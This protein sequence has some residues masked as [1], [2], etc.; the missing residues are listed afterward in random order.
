MNKG[1]VTFIGVL[2]ALWVITLIIDVIMT[3]AL[4]PSRFSAIAQVTEGGPIQNRI[5]IYVIF[6]LPEAVGLFYPPYYFWA[7]WIGLVAVVVAA[8]IIIALYRSFPRFENSS[9]YRISEFFALNLFLS[10]LYIY[11]IAA[12]GHPIKSPISPSPA[13]F[14]ANFFSLTNAGLYEELITRVVFIGIPLFVYYAGT[15]HGNR[16]RTKPKRLPWWRIIWGGGYKFGKPEIIVLVISS[17][18]FGI[19]HAGSWDVSK[20]PQA[21]LGGL[22]LGVLYMRFGLYADV[23]FHFSIDSPSLLLPDTYGNPLAN[24]GTTGFYAIVILVFIA[25]GLIVSVVYIF[26]LG[27]LVRGRQ[28]LQPTA[29]QES[30]ETPNSTQERSTTRTDVVCRN[31]GS[32]KATFF[33]DDVYRCDSCGTVFKRNQ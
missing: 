4:Y 8:F 24:L 21:A 30:T 29:M 23:L 28:R 6:G 22:F 17:V 14:V 9:L 10:Y 25:A 15:S 1:Y 13:N 3:F 26:E 5:P 18:I 27:K 12:V 33:Y 11:F 7:V 2:A 20:I 19:A 16:S 31:C 32:N